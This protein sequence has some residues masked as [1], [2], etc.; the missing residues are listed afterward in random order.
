MSFI[1]LKKNKK[2]LQTDKK[3]PPAAA[4]GHYN[5]K[6]GTHESPKKHSGGDVIIEIDNLTLSYEGVNVIENL[7]L[8]IL[9]GDYVCIIGENGSGKSTLMNAILGLK[10]QAGGSISF[11][12]LKRNE[13]GVLPQQDA[14]QNDFPAL[15]SEV[16][17]SGCLNRA[18]KGPFMSRDFKRLTFE[19][20][21]RLGI[22]SLASHSYR[23]LSGGQ[24]Q[25]VLL[26]RALCSADKMLVLDE[27]VSGLDPKATVDIYSLISDLNRKCGITILMVTH[28]IRSAL[29]YSTKIL[30]L[31]K[32]SV[33]FGTTEEYK[34]LP[35]AQI[36]LEE[37]TIEPEQTLYGDGGFRY[38]GN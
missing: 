19:N 3:I 23:D 11:K 29:A 12:S 24:K 1:S 14:T 15:V 20:L 34:K 28:D 13:I 37:N 8:N 25:R 7:S 26:A 2:A 38:G 18:S 16:V 22:T 27:P 36:Y 30:R 31:N 32:G 21:E 35:E 10:K 17:M 6:Q 4:W 9:S 5:K 33:F